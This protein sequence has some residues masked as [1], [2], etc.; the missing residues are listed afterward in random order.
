M[1]HVQEQ[2]TFGAAKD[3]TRTARVGWW[4]LLLAVVAV[5]LG[6]LFVREALVAD[7]RIDA[8]PWLAPAAD[9]LDGLAPSAGLAALGVLVAVVG[10][11]LVV[12][13]F[14]RRVR[15]R[16]AVGPAG[17]GPGG[18][19]GVSIGIGDAARLARFAAE[20]VDDVLGARATASR[21]KV[22]VTVTAPEGVR[23]EEQVRAAVEQQLAPLADPLAVKV[24][25]KV[26][27][28]LRAEGIGA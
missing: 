23:I 15:T 28:E 16:L 18:R 26:S 6:A 14:G 11:W 8:R 4:G 17:T 19:S 5:V 2:Q 12:L 10:L 3:A 1:T 22:T 21:R 7:G 20:D 13:A 24:V 27:T 9:R 25:T